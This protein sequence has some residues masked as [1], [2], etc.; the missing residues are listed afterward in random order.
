VGRGKVIRVRP[1]ALEAARSACRERMPGRPLIDCLSELLVQA[2]Q[3]VRGEGELG[4]ALEEVRELRRAVEEARR[5]L[6]EV[7]QAIGEVE[8]I[9]R[10]AGVQQAE[11][12]EDI[13]T[14]TAN[15]L[16]SKLQGF[17]SDMDVAVAS[18]IASEMAPII[19]RYVVGP[20]LLYMLSE[21]PCRELSLDANACLRLYWGI[22]DRVEVE[23]TATVKL[24]ITPQYLLDLL[25]RASG[26]G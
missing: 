6:Q 14:S 1:E 13:V 10:Q 2:A 20:V 21:G 12:A 3:T 24:N 5:E 15:R 8:E 23:A 18:R 22:M 26:A 25:K 11:E 9:L 7:S 17:K 4:R 19:K 16:Y